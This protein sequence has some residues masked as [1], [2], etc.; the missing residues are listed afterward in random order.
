M[1]LLL[2]LLLLLSTIDALRPFLSVNI[3]RCSTD[4][5]FRVA[6]Q[7]KVSASTNSCPFHRCVIPITF[8][9]QTRS[10]DGLDTSGA[11]TDG[12]T[13][14]LFQPG[15]VFNKYLHICY[16]NFD[17]AAIMIVQQSGKPLGTPF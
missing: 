17:A 4:L 3:K 11:L 5:H 6:A 1:F 14:H 2:L 8:R 9:R 10:V 15:R 16:N 13:V 7:T 12:R